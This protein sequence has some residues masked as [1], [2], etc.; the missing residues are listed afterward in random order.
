MGSPSLF[1]PIFLLSEDNKIFERVIAGRISIHLNTL[2]P[3]IADCQY[4]VRT[5]MSTIKTIGQIS[6]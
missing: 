1:R 2:G 3:N 5:G 6:L 4:G